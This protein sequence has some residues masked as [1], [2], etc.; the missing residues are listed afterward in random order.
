MRI[1]ICRK[2]SKESRYWLELSESETKLID[3]KSHLI[4]ESTQ[5]IKIF[6]TIIKNASA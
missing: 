3:L 2:E 4:D 5:L 6:T 1:K